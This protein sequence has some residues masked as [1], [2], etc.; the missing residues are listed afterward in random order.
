ME[1]KVSNEKVMKKPKIKII[2]ENQQWYLNTYTW[3]N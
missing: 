3:P 2:E 1:G